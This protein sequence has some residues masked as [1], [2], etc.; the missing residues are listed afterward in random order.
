MFEK[1]QADANILKISVLIQQVLFWI[2]Y[3]KMMNDFFE[4][5]FFKHISSMDI[6]S[7][8]CMNSSYGYQRQTV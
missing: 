3:C 7:Y 4:V 5:G 8:K 1:L 6:I 2:S